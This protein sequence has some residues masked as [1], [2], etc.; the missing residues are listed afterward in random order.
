MEGANDVDKARRAANL[1]QNFPEGRPVNG[2]EGFCQIDKNDIQF[3]LLL[4]TFLLELS[5]CKNHVHGSATTAKTALT[6]RENV[7][8]TYMLGQSVENDACKYFAWYGKE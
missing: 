3:A 6:L 8:V 7:I 5:G 2:V 4:A 1:Q